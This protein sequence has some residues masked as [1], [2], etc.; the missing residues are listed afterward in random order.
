MLVLT[1]I[2][3]KVGSLRLFS[4]SKRCSLEH[5]D[6]WWNG[7]WD[8]EWDGQ[9]QKRFESLVLVFLFILCVC[10]VLKVHEFQYSCADPRVHGDPVFFRVL[11]SLVFFIFPSF[12]HCQVSNFPRVPRSLLWQSIVLLL[13]S[14]IFPVLQHSC[15]YDSLIS[16][17]ASFLFIYF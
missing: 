6:S 2:L 8:W 10:W 1:P 7:D 17:V 15:F 3:M 4:D 12:R 5:D 9:K 16:T 11:C 14:F 13:W